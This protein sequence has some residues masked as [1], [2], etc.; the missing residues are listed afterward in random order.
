MTGRYMPQQQKGRSTPEP[1]RVHT[2]VSLLTRLK[3]VLSGQGEMFIGLSPIPQSKAKESR[4]GGKRYYVDNQ[5]K[6]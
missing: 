4:F 6:G 5:Q 2:A 3:I 1:G